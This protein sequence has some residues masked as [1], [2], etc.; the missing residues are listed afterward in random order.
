MKSLV[1]QLS[2]ENRVVGNDSIISFSFPNIEGKFY[3][4][5]QAKDSKKEDSRSTSFIRELVKILTTPPFGVS[6]NIAI[7]R[8]DNKPAV[9]RWLL[10]RKNHPKGCVHR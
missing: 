6:G 4:K 8:A 5:E 3:I 2:W 10:T 7:W 1:Q 9:S